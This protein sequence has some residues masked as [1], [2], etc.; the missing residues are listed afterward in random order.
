[1]L[2]AVL[3][4]KNGM[5][6]FEADGNSGQRFVKELARA[7]QVSAA[8]TLTSV[9]T[10][11]LISESLDSVSVVVPALQQVSQKCLVGLR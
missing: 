3:S 9:H 1:M 2:F 10:L 4:F 6:G 7:F 11:S 8:V 5:M